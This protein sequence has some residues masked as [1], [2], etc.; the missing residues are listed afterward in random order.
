MAADQVE[1]SKEAP[2]GLAEQA[3]PR[4]KIEEVIDF[5]D[6]LHKFVGITSTKI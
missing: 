2:S 6:A 4:I 5:S 3:T 1:E